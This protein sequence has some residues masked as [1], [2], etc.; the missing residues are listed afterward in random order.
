MSTRELGEDQATAIRERAE[1]LVRERS[2]LTP[3]I[4]TATTREE[5]CDLIH[6]LEVHQVELEMQNQELR[7]T[8][9]ELDLARARY[10][11]LY[12]QAPVGY[13]TLDDAGLIT[14]A[15][16]AIEQALGLERG[17]LCK[18]RFETFIL[19]DDQDTY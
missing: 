8:Q 10:F 17:L 18:Q 4:N 14:S 6:V 13:V 9:L 3:H 11:E 16:L 19:A 1:Q 7:R 2:L 5:I 12:D 15:N